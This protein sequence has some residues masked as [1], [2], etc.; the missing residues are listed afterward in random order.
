MPTVRYTVMD[1]EIVS[2]NRNG[3][4]RDYVPDPL[5]STVALLDENQNITDTFSYWPY[6]EERTRT[7]TTPTP[8]R[9]VGTL[10]YYRDSSG[11]TYVRAREYQQTYGRWMTVDPLWPEEPEYAY[12]GGQ[13]TSLADRSGAGLPLLVWLLVG[14]AILIGGTAAGVKC[15]RD[16]GCRA[17][18]ESE[19]KMLADCWTKFK[20]CGLGELR[21]DPDVC[22]LGEANAESQPGIGSLG[23]IVRVDPKWFKLRA[24]DRCRTLIHE[25]LHCFCR[26][27][28]EE[29]PRHGHLYN[30]ADELNRRCVAGKRVPSLAEVCR[31]IRSGVD[32]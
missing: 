2:E 31:R 7:G 1:G 11:R 16:R 10:G 24:E 22:P 3:T 21:F 8:F 12:T 30:W 28:G 25:G 17:P 5:G 19:R 23:C 4:V 9:F 20:K 6:G 29:N 27:W 18:T 14:G 26:L 13:V 32:P 15:A